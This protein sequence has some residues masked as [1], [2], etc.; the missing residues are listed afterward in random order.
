LVPR[1]SGGLD[2]VVDPLDREGGAE[3]EQKADE[4]ADDDIERQVRLERSGGHLRPVDHRHDVGADAARHA[5][6]FEALE[7]CVVEAAVGVHL[8]LQDGVLDA[9]LAQRHQPGLAFVDL[10]LKRVLAGQG[11]LIIGPQRVGGRARNAAP[12]PGDL[13][14]QRVD[15][16]A[17]LDHF[18][19]VRFEQP[20]LLLILRLERGAL[21]PEPLDRRIADRGHVRLGAGP[22]AV[23]LL[24]GDAIASRRGQRVVGLDQS[25]GVDRLLLPDAAGAAGVDGE[26]DDPLLLGIIHQLTLGLLEAG[27]HRRDALL[28][29][30][31]GV[32][33]RLVAP[34]HVR[35]D[36]VVG[37]S[38]GEPGG[39]IRTRALD[40]DPDQAA[41]ALRL[42]LDAALDH[43]G[44]RALARRPRQILVE[45]RLV[46]GEVGAAGDPLGQR[47]ALQQADLGVEELAAARFGRLDL[48]DLL[49]DHLHALGID[50][51]G[52]LRPIEGGDHQRD[53]DRGE[54]AADGDGRD[55]P[56]PLWR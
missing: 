47:P 6:F 40:L 3:A 22:L 38:V 45:H 2:R 34:L 4:Q 28:E 29:E 21:L 23:A 33:R 8:A 53:D 42:N 25:G 14:G 31:A 10:G 55:Q 16:V 44:R 15:L 9:A 11:G 32:G 1:S 41:L 51:D 50:L 36:E 18:R 56:P 5:D 26:G 30:V 24:G 54:Q 52:G 35:L 49:A 7:K 13:L 17:E 19:E 48:A 20:E 12:L 27:L 37:I 43:P 39:E 46:V